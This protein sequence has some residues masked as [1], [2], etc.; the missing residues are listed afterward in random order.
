MKASD[1]TVG[2]E[3]KMI[4]GGTYRVVD[5]S[6]KQISLENTRLV[7]DMDI[8]MRDLPEMF[9]DIEPNEPNS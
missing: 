1:V 7:A 3:L 4:D 6:G 2:M 5:I 9:I 8:Y